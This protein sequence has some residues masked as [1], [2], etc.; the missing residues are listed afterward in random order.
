MKKFF[1]V[2]NIEGEILSGKLEFVDEREAVEW[3]KAEG[4]TE[5]CFID[6]VTEVM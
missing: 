6:T 5:R 1:I 2:T 4:I 3:V